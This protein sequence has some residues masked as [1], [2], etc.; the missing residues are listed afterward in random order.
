VFVGRSCSAAAKS[1]ST[2]F[3]DGQQCRMTLLVAVAVTSHDRADSRFM[4][5]LRSFLS[6]E[7][8]A[9]GAWPQRARC[10]V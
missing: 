10:G 5:S 6:V 9:P 7:S 3:G 8:V 2:S 4:A 1:W